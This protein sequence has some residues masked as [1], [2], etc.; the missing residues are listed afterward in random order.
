MGNINFWK[1][2][3]VLTTNSCNYKCFFC[4]NEGQNKSAKDKLFLRFKDFRIILDSLKDTSLKEIHFSGGEPFLNEETIEMIL[5]AN[6]STVLEIG[7]ATN[8]TFLTESIIKR[9]AVTRIKL[10]IQFP[11]FNVQDFSRIT[12]NG[13]I[14][15][16]IEKLDLLKSYN[17]P[18]GLNHVL[19]PDNFNSI[20]SIIDFAKI[21]STS[22]RLLPDL[23]NPKSIKLK[24]KIYPYL[25]EIS[26]RKINKGTGALKWLIPRENNTELSVMY[27]DSPCFYKD[28]DSCRNYAEIR[29][30]PDLKLQS[31]I[32][33]EEF[34]FLDFNINKNNKQLILDK[35]QLSWKD[36]I[37]C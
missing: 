16:V 29:L 10:N 1:I 22:I 17:I 27:V 9:L 28:I 26:L 31:C 15:Q 5:Y 21:Y 23:D 11:A 14:Y 24:E 2:L 13:N 18:Y 34:Y 8:T 19:Q 7:C 36:F 37:S 32:K 6:D 12:K 30:L 4:H 25:D 33:K 20:E 35:F 3:R